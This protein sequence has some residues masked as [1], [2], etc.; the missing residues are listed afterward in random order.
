MSIDIDALVAEHIETHGWH[1][2][3]VFPTEDSAPNTPPFVYTAGLTEKDKPELIIFGLAARVGHSILATAVDRL[4]DDDLSLGR[5]SNLIEGLD[6]YILNVKATHWSDYLS[7][8]IRRSRTERPTMLF[9][10]WQI[11]WPDKDGKFPWE[12]GYSMPEWLQPVLS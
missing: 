1:A 11:V 2:T 7:V 3:G 5:A 8:A 6:A 10:C 9:R 4:L 12:S